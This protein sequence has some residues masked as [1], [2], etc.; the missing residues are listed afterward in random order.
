MARHDDVHCVESFLVSLLAGEKVHHHARLPGAGAADDRHEKRAVW[1][2]G[3]Y[4]FVDG[5][6][7]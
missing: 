3:F 6:V 4:L 1:Q 5:F 7:A 2:W